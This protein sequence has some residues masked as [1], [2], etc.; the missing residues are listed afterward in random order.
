MRIQDLQL[1]PAYGQA[2][3]L[4]RWTVDRELELA[5]PVE[6]HVFR[7]PDG[8][9]DWARANTD[10]ITDREYLD[11]GFTFNTRTRIPHYRVLALVGHDRQQVHSPVRGLFESLTRR[12]YGAVRAM[13]GREF[14]QIRADGWRVLHYIPLTRGTVQPGWDPQTDQETNPCP[15][16]DDG[17]GQKY[18][19]GYREPFRSWL[20]PNDVGPLVKQLRDDGLGMFDDNKVVTRM[21]AFPR[22][23]RGHLIVRPETDDRWAVTEIVKPY[24]FKGIYPI[25]YMA[26]LELLRRE[27]PAYRLPLPPN[28]EPNTWR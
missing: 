28:L 13:I 15:G 8:A 21:L 14:R 3:T 25:A 18:V 9:G 2:Q 6:Y 24:A 22:P 4:V 5:E 17:Y 26:Q 20:H 10:P 1:Q 19:G 7:S 16:P 11:T 12:E 27:D 23:E